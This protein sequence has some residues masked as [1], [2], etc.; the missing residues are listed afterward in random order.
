MMMN[1]SH[2]DP[3]IEE[4]REIRHNISARFGH[5]PER[6]VAHYAELQERYRERLVRTVPTPEQ[7]DTPAV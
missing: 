1:Q 7:T 5:D 6:L 3:V 4:I 2:T